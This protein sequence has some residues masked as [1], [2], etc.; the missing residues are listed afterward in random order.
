MKKLL[1][2][3]ISFM[4]ILS[5]CAGAADDTPPP[6]VPPE[7]ITEVVEP[8]AAPVQVPESGPQAE[9]KQEPESEPEP[10]P[11]E[12]WPAHFTALVEAMG[13]HEFFS[14]AT[15]FNIMDVT[16]DDTPK[17]LVEF[18]LPMGVGPHLLVLSWDSPLEAIRNPQTI[19]SGLPLRFFRS[20][21]T[22]EII[23]SSLVSSY[24]LWSIYYRFSEDFTI[25]RVVRCLGANN[26]SLLKPSEAYG[27]EVVEEFIATPGL[28]DLVLCGCDIYLG[29][30]ATDPTIVHLVNLALEGFT[31][32]PAPPI[33]TFEGLASDDRVFFSPEHV[34]TIQAWI[35]EVAESWGGR[36]AGEHNR[37]RS[38]AL[39]DEL[40]IIDAVLIDYVGIAAFEQWLDAT[41]RAYPER[42]FTVLDFLEYFNISLDRYVEFM[43]Q[44]NA[45]PY[46]IQEVVEYAQRRAS[47]QS[48]Q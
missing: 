1:P 19:L 23:H 44:T 28:Q 6:E 30:N 7:P 41:V 35:F 24:G 20:D 27:S 40:T 31:E 11:S 15:S 37:H 14:F 45:L 25:F 46:R 32:I 10:L 4:L 13:E 12:N 22:G 26:H 33:Y 34:E 38:H 8:P 48:S 36:P 18:R 43:S 5:A 9:P 2:C 16:L 3:I 21:N 39:P 47:S 17:L 29:R 42:L